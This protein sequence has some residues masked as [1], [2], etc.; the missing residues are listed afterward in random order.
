MIDQ[1]LRLRAQ[2]EPDPDVRNFALR[3]TGQPV[4][5]APGQPPPNAAGLRKK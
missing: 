5:S 1:T 4:P 2:V 3:A